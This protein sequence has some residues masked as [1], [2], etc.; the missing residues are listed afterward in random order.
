MAARILDPHTDAPILVCGPH[1]TSRCGAAGEQ[2]D[3]TACA[4]HPVLIDRDT[5]DGPRVLRVFVSPSQRTCP[6][7]PPE[8]AEH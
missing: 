5:S 3:R 7:G 6:F 2:A 8:A 1:W 4:G